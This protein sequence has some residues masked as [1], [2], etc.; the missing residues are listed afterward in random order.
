[1]MKKMKNIKIWMAGAM[2]ASST[3]FF[4]SCEIDIPRPD[5]YTE[6]AIWSDPT[7][8]EMSIN[9]LYAEFKKFQFGVFPNLG[10]DSA[11]AALSD[12]M[13][14]TSI[15]AGNGTAN[16]LASN[17]NQFSAGKIARAS[18]RE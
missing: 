13:Q 5:R 11:S 14:Y 3:L 6:E 10:Y 16:I 17:A 1:M 9:G 7:T 8:A 15:T 4:Q 18:C 12:I 2:V